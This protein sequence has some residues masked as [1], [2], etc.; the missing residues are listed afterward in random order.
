MVRARAG[1]TLIELMIVVAII[2]ILAAIAIPNFQLFQLRS[3]ASEG[4]SNLAAIRVA[5]EGYRSEFRTFVPAPAPL[6]RALAALDG[7]KANWPAVAAGFDIVGFEP[8]GEVFYS[9]QVT[10]GPAGCGG[11]GG[12]CTQFTAEAASDIDD[13]DT[14]NWWGYVRPDVLGG[15]VAGTNCVATGVYNPI[16]VAQDLLST[17]GPCQAGMGQGTF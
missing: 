3:R 5:Q 7:D 9:Y 2:G 10:T 14:L 4:K 6:P 16:S 12:P 13:D 15:S 17:V 1:F 11:G 8:E